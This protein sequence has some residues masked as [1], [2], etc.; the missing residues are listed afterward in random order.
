ME[1]D[2]ERRA[3]LAEQVRNAARQLDPVARAA[4]DYIR[5]LELEAKEQ[6]VHA[7]GEDMLRTQGAARGLGK[8]FTELTTIPPNIKPQTKTAQER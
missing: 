8:A 5:L 7:S 4:I 6:L 1:T 3:R 2:K